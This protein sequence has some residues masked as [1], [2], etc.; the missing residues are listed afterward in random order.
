VPSP[1]AVD[2]ALA[3]DWYKDPVQ[4]TDPR[5]WPNTQAGELVSSGKY[6]Y[7]QQAGPQEAAGRALAAMLCDAI[8]RHAVLGCAT[9]IL[10]VPGH[11]STRLSFGSRLAA[12]VARD[13]GKPMS[14][15]MTRSAYR[16]ESKFGGTELARMLEDEF[17]VSEQVRSQSVLI[18]DDVIR[19][20]T[21]MAAV[22][23]AARASG[24]R[25][26]LAICAARTIRR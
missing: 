8:Y 16:P 9:V 21:S 2:L 12:T 15:V 4:G 25:Q 14:R 24:A 18:V 10:N 7:R 13:T 23:K 5:S 20:G 3:L 6:R 19:S 26:V 22:A 17:S 11:D 1:Q